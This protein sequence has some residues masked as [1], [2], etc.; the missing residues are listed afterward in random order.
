MDNREVVSLMNKYIETKNQMAQLDADKKKLIDEA[1]PK[2]VREK[3]AEI[4]TEFAG[5][6]EAAQKE[7]AQLEETIKG[8]V[9]SLRESLAVKGMKAT[10]HPGRT[11]WDAK[12]LE[13]L[14]KTNPD[15]ALIIAPFK[16]QGKDY[17]AFR[18]EG[19]KA[20]E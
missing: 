4:E 7:L 19:E 8:G 9:V 16:K 17:A 10:F 13:G 15:V 20:E 6:N 1:I 14:G 11:T 12:G 5:K 18:F 3:I 2:E